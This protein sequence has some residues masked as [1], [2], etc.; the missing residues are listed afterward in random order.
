MFERGYGVTAIANGHPVHGD[1]LFRIGSLTK[2]FTAAAIMQLIEQG[3][4]SLDDPITRF[5]PNFPMQGHR[6]TVEH[7]LNHTSG[8]HDYTQTGARWFSRVADDLTHEEVVAL[9]RDEPP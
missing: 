3:R 1:T 4:V 9:F 7:L 5:L 6:I 2:Q 8:I